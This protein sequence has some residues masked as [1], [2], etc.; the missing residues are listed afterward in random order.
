MSLYTLYVRVL[1]LNMAWVFK[2]RAG[3]IRLVHLSENLEKQC[4]AKR[5]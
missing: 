4:N 2:L 1:Q 5:C 3:R